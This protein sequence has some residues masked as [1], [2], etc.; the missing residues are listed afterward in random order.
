MP[1]DYRFKHPKYLNTWKPCVKMHETIAVTKNK[2]HQL[3]CEIDIVT[4]GHDLWLVS[5][6]RRLLENWHANI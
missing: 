2:T 1:A 3:N 6:P 5:Q 4:L